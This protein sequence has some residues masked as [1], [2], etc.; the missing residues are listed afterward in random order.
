[1]QLI[2]AQSNDCIS[3]TP[4]CTGTSV[5]FPAST[6]T[7]SPIGPFYDCLFTQ[8]N[9]AFFQLQIGQPGNITINL[10]STPLVDID[11]ICWGPFNDPNTMCDS[12]TAAYVED[13]SYSPASIEICD[14][15]NAVPGQFYILLITNFSG[16]ACNIDF[17]SAATSTGSTNCCIEGDAGQDNNF[18][19][20]NS[21]PAFIMEN[22]L[23]GSP[24][25]GGVWY[26]DSWNIVSNNFNPATGAS[27]TYAYI[28]Q[29]I[30]VAG[31]SVVCP[32]DTAFLVIDL[33]SCFDV[34]FI[35]TEASCLGNDGAI[36]CFLDTL[37]LSWQFELYDMAGN[38]IAI[39]PNINTN[40]YTFSNLFPGNYRVKILD[41]LGGFIEE[42]VSVGQV[43]SSMSV[44][45][46]LSEV[47]CYNGDD[48]EIGVLVSGGSLPYY[49]YINGVLNPLPYP[50]DS[51]FSGLGIGT[52]IISVMDS[53][54]CMI[55]DTIIIMAPNSPLQV[56]TS[57]K[58]VLCHSDS[59]SIAVAY[60]VGGTGPYSYLWY[61]STGSSPA[62]II[63]STDTAFGLT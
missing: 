9:P 56:L 63:S 49:Y 55:R 24:S 2:N 34:N 33:N 48:G 10:Q 45:S 8:P 3:A 52:Y 57:S 23:N 26:D 1:M 42:T 18:T 43:Q 25:S 19:D 13:C 62:S 29:G 11:F 6:S 53:N 15:T 30:P 60:A 16:V 14:I 46:T 32:D 21:A 58:V 37:L 28:V 54:D 50:G 27:G 47:T 35:S 4:F 59:N 36:S 38:N 61:S 51:V 5:S 22:E 44:I 40:S 41:N 7:V 31:S 17:A 20:C 12:L 39:V